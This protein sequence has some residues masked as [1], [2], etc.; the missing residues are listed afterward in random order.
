MSYLNADFHFV[1]KEAKTIYKFFIHA[2]NARTVMIGYL[3][4][5]KGPESITHSI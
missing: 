2:Y 4:F 3:F 1:R 5:R